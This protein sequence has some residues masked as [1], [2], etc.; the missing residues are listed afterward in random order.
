M[1]ED[2]IKMLRKCTFYEDVEYFSSDE[3]QENVKEQLDVEEIIS[4]TNDEEYV[5]SEKI[6]K[7]HRMSFEV[8]LKIIMTANENPKWSFKYL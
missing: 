4:S 2:F 6:A 8:K 1:F 5:L 7:Y 3:A